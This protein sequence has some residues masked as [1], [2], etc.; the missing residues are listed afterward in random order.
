M[1]FDNTLEPLSFGGPDYVDVVAFHKDILGIDLRTQFHLTIKLRPEIP[2]FH[3]SPLGAGTCLLEVTLLGLVG[4]LFH[5]IAVRQLNRPV[6]I[7]LG[8]LYLRHHA[9]AGLNNRAGNVLAISSEHTGHSYLFSN[10][11]R[12]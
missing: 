11:S 8:I 6:A 7:G 10:N 3:N 9:R 5:L 1:A 2:E 12:H 4:I